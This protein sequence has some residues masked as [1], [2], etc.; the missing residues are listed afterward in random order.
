METYSSDMRCYY[1]NR[2]GDQEYYD[3]RRLLIRAAQCK[4]VLGVIKALDV[5][6][7]PDSSTEWEQYHQ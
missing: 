5:E 7:V 1:D 2:F 6:S 3:I 4:P